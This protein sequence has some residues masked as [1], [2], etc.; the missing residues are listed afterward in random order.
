MTVASEHDEVSEEMCER[1]AELIEGSTHLEQVVL[2]ASLANIQDFALTLLEQNSRLSK[3]D[4]IEETGR[5]V[6]W[7][8]LLPDE[9]S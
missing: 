4:F 8:E 2:I 7:N 5:D 6:A 9:E 3:K 1:V